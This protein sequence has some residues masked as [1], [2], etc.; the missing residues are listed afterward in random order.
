MDYLQWAPRPSAS[1]LSCLTLSD[2]ID[3]FTRLIIWWLISQTVLEQ[4]ART[5][6]LPCGRESFGWFVPFLFIWVWFYWIDPESICESFSH[7]SRACSKPQLTAAM[8]R[9]PE[10]RR[11]G[12]GIISDGMGPTRD[13]SCQK[14]VS[15]SKELSRVSGMEIFLFFLTAECSVQHR[16]LAGVSKRQ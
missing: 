14:V 6:E 15:G 7:H 5:W 4:L 3:Q 9:I 12:T 11:Q 1:S 2:L 13:S 16:P 10:G 8:T